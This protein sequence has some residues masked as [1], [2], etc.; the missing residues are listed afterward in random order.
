ML[1]APSVDG[2]KVW[3]VSGYRVLNLYGSGGCILEQVIDVLTKG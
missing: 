3:L 2:S 1:V